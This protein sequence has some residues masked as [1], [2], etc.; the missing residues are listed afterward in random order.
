MT[1]ERID[2]IVEEHNHR[3]SQLATGKIGDFGTASRMATI[4]WDPELAM[5]AELNAKKCK[6]VHSP[7]RNTPEYKQSGQNLG[8][9]SSSHAYHNNNEIIKHFLEV[10]FDEYK[11]VTESMIKSAPG[12]G[13]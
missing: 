6:K 7:C 11:L 12:P 10:W 3:R 4:Q 1:Q 5:L 2:M 9:A 13:G 8:M